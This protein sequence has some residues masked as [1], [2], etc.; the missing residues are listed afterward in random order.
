M[1]LSDV[2]ILPISQLQIHQ[3]MTSQIT[4]HIEYLTQTYCIIMLILQSNMMKNSLN[5]K[6]YYNLMIIWDCGLL[7]LG[8]PVYD[9]KLVLHSIQ[10]PK[11]KPLPNYQKVLKPA[12]ESRFLNQ[13]NLSIKYR[14]IILSIGKGGATF[15]KD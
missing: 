13:I 11:S 12:N 2:L 3:M 9:V 1:I 8:H 10:G 5:G 7:F 4:S 14:N 6:F 15:L